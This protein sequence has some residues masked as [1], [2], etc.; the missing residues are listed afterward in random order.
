MA[1]IPELLDAYKQGQTVF[2]RGQELANAATWKN[3]TL[4]GN[5]LVGL[6][7]SAATLTKTLG[8]DLQV[9]DATLAHAGLGIAALVTIINN[10][11]HVITSSKVGFSAPSA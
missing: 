3:Q 4:A 1:L 10:V 8:Y 7:V 9:D 11:I 5:T 2:N 6:L